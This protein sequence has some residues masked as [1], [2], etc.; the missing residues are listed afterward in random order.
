[1]HVITLKNVQDERP[2]FEVTMDNNLKFHKHTATG[3][4]QANQIRNHEVIIGHQRLNTL[5]PPHAK[6]SFRTWK[7]DMGKKY[8]S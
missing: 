3:I 5:F 8:Q 7:F 1:M 6:R 4:K 2:Q